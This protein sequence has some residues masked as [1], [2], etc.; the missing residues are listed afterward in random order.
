[1][2]RR[3]HVANANAFLK[4][5]CRLLQ[6]PTTPLIP[7]LSLF[8]VLQ[9]LV[10]RHFMSQRPWSS[11]PPKQE[12]AERFFQGDLS[13]ANDDF[14]PC[15]HMAD[16][17]LL[18]FVLPLPIAVIGTGIFLGIALIHNPENLVQMYEG[19]MAL[20]RKGKTRTIVLALIPTIFAIVMA[21]ACIWTV[22]SGLL[23]LREWLRERKTGQYRYGLLLTKDY[24]AVRTLDSP[25]NQ[26][27][28]ILGRREISQFRMKMSGSGGDRYRSIVMDRYQPDGTTHTMYLPCGAMKE[29]HSRIYSKLQTWL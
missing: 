6:H 12:I 3:I 29:P 17:W 26:T 23:A 19:F 4:H 18:P 1:M 14:I 25:N 2:A 13:P 7:R 20:D 24:L 16:V 27:P 15:N 21:I 22:Q 10:F 5:P 11:P 9:I 8:S 28:L